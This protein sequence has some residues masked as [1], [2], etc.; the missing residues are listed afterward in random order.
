[1]SNIFKTALLLGSLLWQSIG[2]ASDTG[3][4]TS[5][6]NDHAQI[7]LQAD[8]RDPAQP[9]VLLSLALESGWKTYWQNPGEGGNCP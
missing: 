4:L 9:R 3:W 2:L 5:P 6:R 7:R 1:M 8:S